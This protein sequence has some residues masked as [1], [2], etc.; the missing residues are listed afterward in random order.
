MEL[1][2]LIWHTSATK[3][4]S[5]EEL[6]SNFF[7]KVFVA[8][9]CSSC[10][11]DEMLIFHGDVSAVPTATFSVNVVWIWISILSRTL[12]IFVL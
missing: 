3:K 9:D 2:N 8:E 4:D 12:D 11:T 1:R 5:Q 6:Q 7:P 10:V